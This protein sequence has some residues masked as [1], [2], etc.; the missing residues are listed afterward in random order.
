MTAPIFVVALAAVMLGQVK[1][2]V[3]LAVDVDLVI[4]KFVPPGE[5][6]DDVEL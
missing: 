3:A 2:P 6:L 4:P 5:V 1:L